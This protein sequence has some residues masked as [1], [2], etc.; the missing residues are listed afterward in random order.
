V[1]CISNLFA[2]IFCAYVCA[3]GDEQ[4]EVWNKNGMVVDRVSGVGDGA[5]EF[6]ED[7]GSFWTAC[8]FDV[9]ERA[10]S[11]RQNGVELFSL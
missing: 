4:A 3:H 9:V 6:H 8:L 10:A 7:D 1:P 11:S 2:L 5:K